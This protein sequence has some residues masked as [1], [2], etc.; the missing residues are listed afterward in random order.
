MKQEVNYLTEL[1]RS[2][3]AE[4]FPAFLTSRSESYLAEDAWKIIHS[5]GQMCL[6]VSPF[7][8]Q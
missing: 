1:L 4:H 7:N 8:W 6:Q 5:Q 3:E 2:A